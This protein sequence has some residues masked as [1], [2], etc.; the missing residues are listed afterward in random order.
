MH[1][2]AHLYTLN[3][4]ITRSLSPLLPFSPCAAS[5]GRCCCPWRPVLLRFVPAHLYLPEARMTAYSSADCTSAKRA[6]GTFDSH[7][8]RCCTSRCSSPCGPYV[9]DRRLVHAV[10]ARD[11]VLLETRAFPRAVWPRPPQ[12][13]QRRCGTLRFL[14]IWCILDSIL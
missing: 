12:A 5:F 6:V 7:C 9:Q 14:A 13:P 4:H 1:A 3:T 11:A 8:R 2:Y 10:L